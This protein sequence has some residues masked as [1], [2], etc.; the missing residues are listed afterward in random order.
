M[1]KQLFFPVEKISGY[2]F[3]DDDFNEYLM[4]KYFIQ[5]LLQNI[6]NLNYDSIALVYFENSG[7][8]FIE[9]A[10]QIAPKKLVVIESPLYI[11][12]HESLKQNIKN[13]GLKNIELHVSSS[14]FEYISRNQ[15]VIFRGEKIPITDFI[16]D[17]YDLGL[18]N[19]VVSV[20]RPMSSDV[21][22]RKLPIE[23]LLKTAVIDQTKNPNL[24]SI[25]SNEKY[26]RKWEKSIEQIPIIIVTVEKN[27]KPKDKRKFIQKIE[28]AYRDAEKTEPRH[29]V[30]EKVFPD[31]VK[32]FPPT[33]SK[34]L[35]L[36]LE[37]I[38]DPLHYKIMQNIIDWMKSKIRG[39]NNKIIHHIAFQSPVSVIPLAKA[40][41][42]V[43]VYRQQLNMGR[44]YDKEKPE[45]FENSVLINTETRVL[46]ND[47]NI[48]ELDNVEIGLQN[49]DF[50]V[51]V[52]DNDILF[53]TQ[54]NPE[55]YVNQILESKVKNVYFLWIIYDED[56]QMNINNKNV[57]KLA[58]QNFDVTLFYKDIAK[59]NP[60]FQ[61]FVDEAIETNRYK[62][63]IQLFIINKKEEQE[64]EEAELEEAH[65]TATAPEPEHEAKS[66]SLESV[67]GLSIETDN[68]VLLKQDLFEFIE[69]FDV[70][71]EF[72]KVIIDQFPTLDANGI[73]VVSSAIMNK[74]KNGV[75]YNTQLEKM[76]SIVLPKIKQILQ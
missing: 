25:L 41:K 22:W 10:K 50:Q 29:I 71:E 65:A 37:Q 8:L 39:M 55:R 67:K 51:F 53:T 30:N 46:D 45:E 11:D 69:D 52:Q 23:D 14:P 57:R 34:N 68:Y 18:S 33:K 32:Y 73:V 44:I 66:G 1:F 31:I 36:E 6:N 70:R 16:Y 62:F 9:L 3:E 74:V 61:K 15:I 64:I 56:K 43:N 42:S 13:S 58:Q 59:R 19:K 5:E 49:K 47:I 20:N 63:E 40:V 26:K 48:F 54:Q 28:Q 12:F 24:K 35:Q 38:I 17:L 72:A 76:I 27:S 4:D 60:K 7:S 2:K 21:N 75:S